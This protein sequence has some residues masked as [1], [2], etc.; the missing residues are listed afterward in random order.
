MNITKKLKDI[1]VNN[2]RF[3]TKYNKKIPEK[4]TVSQADIKISEE[5]ILGDIDDILT[6]LS[7]CRRSFN[8]V[9]DNDLIDAVIYEELALTA[10]YTYLIRQ[11]RE[12]GISGRTVLK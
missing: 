6:E 10:R 7:R 12:N 9:T 2:L 8:L 3:L 4:L 5:E 1:L 11:A